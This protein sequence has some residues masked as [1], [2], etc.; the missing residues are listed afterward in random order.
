MQGHK[1]SK[2]VRSDL[3]EAQTISAS[4]QK[5]IIVLAVTHVESTDSKTAPRKARHTKRSFQHNN[6]KHDI[7]SLII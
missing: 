6:T 3:D 7:V 1:W 4:P 5:V 2:P